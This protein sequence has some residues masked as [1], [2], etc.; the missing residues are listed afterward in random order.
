M[1]GNKLSAPGG[2]SHLDYCFV[3]WITNIKS[4]AKH[5]RKLFNSLYINLKNAHGNDD[6][7]DELPAFA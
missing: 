5:V 1:L 4:E 2:C 7:K 3:V 6:L